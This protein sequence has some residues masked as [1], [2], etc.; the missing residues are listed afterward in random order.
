MRADAEAGSLR[1]F[2]QNPPEPAERPGLHP[3]LSERHAPTH[4]RE[5][6][7]ILYVGPMVMGSTTLQ[8]FQALQDLGHDVEAVTT[9]LPNSAPLAQ[10][11][12][13]A[14]AWRKVFG[15]RDL[16]KANARMLAAVQRSRFDLVWIDKGLTIRPRTLQAIRKAQP[17]C[18]IVGFSPDDMMNAANQSRNFLRGL[19]LYDS[20]ITTKSYNVAE[21]AQLG[22]PQVLFMENGYDPRTHRP[23]PVTPRDRESLGGPVG[24]VGQWEPDRAASLRA[25]A[26]AGMPLRVWGYTWERM[27]DVPPGLRLENRPLWGDDYAKAICAFDINLCFLRKCN[28]DRQ[29]TR[30]VEI[31]ACGGFMLAER[32]E[33][34]LGL[35]EEG[36]EAEFFSSDEELLA[37][38]QYYLQHPDQRRRIARSGHER[39]QRSGYSY[40]ER[41]CRVLHSVASDVEA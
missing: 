14:R 23:L 39:C 19:P 29:T 33:E 15:Q 37:K 11:P 2:H 34:H 13:F 12:L 28:R 8:R 41:L 40:R 4:S 18:R 20:Y 9:V 35:F 5:G 26:L 24:F 16:V 6:P 21:L 17:R 30:S 32:T 10:P 22:C 3:G 38:I 31:P 27:T 25:A 1:R 36:K 7:R